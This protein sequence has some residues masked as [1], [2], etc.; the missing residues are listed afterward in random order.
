MAGNTRV[1]GST[2][3]QS[4]ESHAL[5]AAVENKAAGKAFNRTLT[6]TEPTI[7]L[8]D[9]VKPFP[10][11]PE[12]LRALQDFTITVI[13]DP[14]KQPGLEAPESPAIPESNQSPAR[15]MAAR[16]GVDRGK[17]DL[18]SNP[19][20]KDRTLKSTKPEKTNASR[21][22][23]LKDAALQI[24]KQNQVSKAFGAKESSLMQGCL[25]GLDAVSDYQN[26]GIPR[27][28]LEKM[29]DVA[30][31][32][33]VIIAIRPVERICRTLIEEGY[34]SKPLT[35]K[36]KSANWG[37]QAGFLPV[38]QALSKKAGLSSE[39]EKYNAYA[40]KCIDKGDA[41][42]QQLSLSTARLTELKDLG[43][44]K[45]TRETA[46]EAGYQRAEAFEST[47]EA[48][49][50]R[51]TQSFEAHQ[52]SDGQWD[53][54]VVGEDGLEKLEVL[55]D[56][57]GG[58]MTADFDLLFVDAHYE[59]IDLGQQ[60]RRHG[61]DPKLGIY[62]NRMSKVGQDINQALDR[63]PGRDMVHHG[64]DT[65]NPATE[66]EANLPTT[67]LLPAKQIG[68]YKSPLM[69]KTQVEL[70]RFMRTMQKMGYKM[71]VNPLWNGLKEVASEPVQ[72][73]I[74]YFEKK[75]PIAP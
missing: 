53:I 35:I 7:S 26:Q 10:A 9:A 49:G 47:L 45:N 41:V 18:K 22:F 66:M 31:Q 24:S 39:V 50:R 48:D 1:G 58:P 52:R 68:M 46:P 43:T 42:A 20:L 61:F 60:D 65:S 54:F 63:G 19:F 64:A 27:G 57:E 2:S 40:Q 3:T 5:P 69:I 44:L 70:A 21:R 16:S 73:K 14:K 30:E 71:D 36:A 32:D 28:Y 12:R 51:V 8:T 34:A 55:A 33:K 37:P 25:M 59:D 72:E 74:S 56:K 13:P 29:Q 11:F 23:S 62:S 17:L 75:G 15:K 6:Q 4:I 38:N 67:I